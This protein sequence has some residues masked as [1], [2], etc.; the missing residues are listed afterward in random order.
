MIRVPSRISLN[1][2]TI[3]ASLPGKIT[4]WKYRTTAGY[5]KIPITTPITISIT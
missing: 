5:D 2:I 4:H 3:T 1:G